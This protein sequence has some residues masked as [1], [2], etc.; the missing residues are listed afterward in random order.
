MWLDARTLQFRPAEPWPPLESW[1][2][3]FGGEP[4]FVSTLMAAP[5]A[6]SPQHGATGLSPVHSIALTF[7]QPLP[8]DDLARMVSIELR[9]LGAV[10]SR[11]TSRLGER[12]FEVGLFRSLG[13][14]PGVDA[15]D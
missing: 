11:P 13:D 7:R 15:V 8:I 9:P 2:W 6:T 4:V 5:I 3:E 14:E 10:G 1:S 12:D